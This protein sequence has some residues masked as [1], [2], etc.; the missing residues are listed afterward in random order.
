MDSM[1]LAAI[2]A[3]KAVAVVLDEYLEVL[4]TS[5]RRRKS[6][7]AYRVTYHPA[8]TYW[9]KEYVIGDKFIDPYTSVKAEGKFRRLFGL[10]RA[11][12]ISIVS[13]AKAEVF[14][15]RISFYFY[16][17][18]L[19][20]HYNIHTLLLITITYFAYVNSIFIY[21]IGLSPTLKQ[22]AMVFHWI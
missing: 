5:K 2:N 17:P 9:W 4:N 1:Q 18:I 20:C 14:I 11:L 19:L 21:R 13:T 6:Y 16:I 3:V 22:M 15:Y 8:S 7:Y 10:P 12:F